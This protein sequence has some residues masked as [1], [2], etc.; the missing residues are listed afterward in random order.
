M[1]ISSCLPHSLC[2]DDSRTVLL[3]IQFAHC[4]HPELL[5]PASDLAS[6]SLDLGSSVPAVQASQ[7]PMLNLLTMRFAGC[8]V[9]GR[10]APAGDR[11]YWQHQ[12]S[13]RAA[14]QAHGQAQVQGLVPQPVP[15]VPLYTCCFTHIRFLARSKYTGQHHNSTSLQ[16]ASWLVS[17][18]SQSACRG[19]KRAVW[20]ADRLL[21]MASAPVSL[22]WQ[23]PSDWGSSMPIFS[24]ILYMQPQS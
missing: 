20:S 15:P 16:G 4:A 3:F 8:G 1:Y 6:D 22:L 12:P 21:Q 5:Q 23:K 13:C 19:P 14:R 9:I 10:C 17:S 24:L 7:S 11:Q 18:P 2:Q